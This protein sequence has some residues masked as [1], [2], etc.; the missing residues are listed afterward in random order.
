MA[1]AFTAALGLPDGT[2]LPLLLATC[3]FDVVAAALLLFDRRGRAA[4]WVQ[5]ALVGGYTLG[6]TA[7]M[8]A[9]WADPFGPLLKNLAVLALV[10]VNA[11][12]SDSR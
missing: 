3:L 6:L 7:A 1:A 4:L 5:L 12:L 11:V 9:L 8:P 10:A 2:A